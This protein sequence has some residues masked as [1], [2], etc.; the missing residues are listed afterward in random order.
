MQVDIIPA[1]TL[2]STAVPSLSAFLSSCVQYPNATSKGL[3]LALKR[4]VRDPQDAAAIAQ[5]LENWIKALGQQRK[6]NGEVGLL[7]TNKDLEKNEH[8]VWVIKSQR[9][10]AK[11]GG[12]SA[13]KKALPPLVKVFP[14]YFA[15]YPRGKTC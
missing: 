3:V 7:P 11:K 10:I 6:V 8:G 14:F 9:R 13:N 5:V 1:T 2:P 4:W 12:A 15:L